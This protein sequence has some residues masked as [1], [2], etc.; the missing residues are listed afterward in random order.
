MSWAD[1]R[2]KDVVQQRASGV[3]GQ[4]NAA[5]SSSTP[6]PAASHTRR[7]LHESMGISVI[8]FHC[9]AHVEPEGTEEPNATHSIVFVRRGLFQ[10]RQHHELLIADP[11]HILFFNALHAY[12]YAHPLP[13]GDH[14]TILAVATDTALNLIARQSPWD[15]EEPEKP[16]RVPYAISSQRAVRTHYELLA[17]LQ[18]SSPR[19]VIEDAMVELA[20]EA[21]RSAYDSYRKERKRANYSLTAA[22]SLRRHHDLTEATKLEINESLEDLPSLNELALDL[23]C[24]SFHLSRIFHQTAGMSLRRYVSR[25]RATVAADR[26]AANASDLTELA[27]DLGFADHSHFTNTFRREWGVSPS[28]FRARFAFS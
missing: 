14:C 4:G 22:G 25:L 20:E 9:W 1:T 19:L 18:R 11:N 12:R 27:L 6:E 28:R 15:A 3:I 2:V 26:L 16:F 23:G 24:S 8:D 13:G 7:L 17:L 5:S 10:R 21:L